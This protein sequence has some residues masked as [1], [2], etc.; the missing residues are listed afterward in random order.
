MV[1]G[2]RASTVRSHF[3]VKDHFHRN[4][5]Y[6]FLARNPGFGCPFRGAVGKEQ[7]LVDVVGTRNFHCLNTCSSGIMVAREPSARLA[8]VAMFIKD[9]FSYETRVVTHR[10]G[11]YQT[12]LGDS[13]MILATVVRDSLSSSGKIKS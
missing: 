1:R 6:T 8:F 5:K 3:A 11:R 12:R 2:S 4:R 7:R 9:Q 13:E 10:I